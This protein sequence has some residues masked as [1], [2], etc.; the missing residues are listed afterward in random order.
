MFVL[1][2][3]KAPIISVNFISS[4]AFEGYNFEYLH[5]HITPLSN[6]IMHPF[7]FKSENYEVVTNKIRS[8]DVQM[9]VMWPMV[10]TSPHK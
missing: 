7:L 3:S 10:V 6:C 5:C 9:G 1:G 2:C 8:R 4:N